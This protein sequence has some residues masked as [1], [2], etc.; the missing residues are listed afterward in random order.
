AEREPGQMVEQVAAQ[1]E[2][3]ALPEAGEAAD[4]RALEHPA[5]RR[6]AEVDRDDDGQVVLDAGADALVDRVPD[7]QP[8]ARLRG[9]VAGADE[10]ERESQQAPPPQIPPQPPHATG[11]LSLPRGGA[12]LRERLT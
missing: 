9:R 1:A 2:H 3:H 5:D 8:A 6:D 7:E 12:A 10:D 11:R 4:E